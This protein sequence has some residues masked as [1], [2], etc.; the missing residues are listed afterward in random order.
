[1]TASTVDT[2][3]TGLSAENYVYNRIHSSGS[4]LRRNFLLLPNDNGLFSPRYNIVENLTNASSGID[5]FTDATFNATGSSVDYGRISL[6]NLISD[7][8]T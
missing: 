3:I 8:L 4:I 5:G 6:E 2:T 1:M 7:W